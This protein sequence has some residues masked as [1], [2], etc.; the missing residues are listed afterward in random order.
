MGFFGSLLKGIGKGLAGAASLIPGVG[1]YV[2]DGLNSIIGDA[3]RS[4]AISQQTSL[5]KEMMT[6]QH[7][8]NRADWEAQNAYNTPLAQMQRITDAG[9]NPLTQ[10]FTGFQASLPSAVSS[11]SAP[12][13][14]SLLNYQMALRQFNLQSALN[15]QELKGKKI[16]NKAAAAEAEA[17]I[18][19]ALE[20]KKEAAANIKAGDRIITPKPDDEHDWQVDDAG[21]WYFEEDGQKYYTADFGKGT[22][23]RDILRNVRYKKELDEAET[24][25]YNKYLAD[26]NQRIRT[27]EAIISETFGFDMAAEQLHELT[28]TIANI[29]ARTDLTKEQK[30]QLEMDNDIWRSIGVEGRAVTKVL[31]FLL[32][33]IRH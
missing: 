15:Y 2:S 18:A 11:Q 8:L 7:D 17:R 30:F 28:S 29:E 33:F 9:I 16:E 32:G 19:E 24:V 23:Q 31:Q 3:E 10:S 21:Y 22:S 13:V 5:N 12:D 20:R 14:S 1:S 26:Y 27:I 6:Y 4:D 25:R